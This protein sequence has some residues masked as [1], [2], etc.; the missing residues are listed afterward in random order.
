MSKIRRTIVTT[1]VNVTVYDYVTENDVEFV[2]KIEHKVIKLEGKYTK[3]IR[4]SRAIKSKISTNGKI[5]IDSIKYESKMFETTLEKFLTV[6][7]EIKGE[8]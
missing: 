7:T 1:I 6:A 5:V 2:P 4:L 8:D 3:G